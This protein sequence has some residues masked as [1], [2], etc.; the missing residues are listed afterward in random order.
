MLYK[1]LDDDCGYDLNQVVSALAPAETQRK[2]ER[3]GVSDKAK[4]EQSTRR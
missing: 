3:V 1:P 4:G 2:G